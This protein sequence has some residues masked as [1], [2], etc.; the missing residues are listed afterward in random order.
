MLI[1]LFAFLY[2][3][4]SLGNVVCYRE[5]LQDLTLPMDSS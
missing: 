4:P 3:L 2:L 5:H 1:N